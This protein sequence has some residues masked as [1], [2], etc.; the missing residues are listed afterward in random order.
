M[1]YHFWI[2]TEH[3]FTSSHQVWREL[4]DYSP[5][6]LLETRN[7]DTTEIADNILYKLSMLQ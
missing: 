6:K 4:I 7:G 3:V 1:L 2:V 5:K